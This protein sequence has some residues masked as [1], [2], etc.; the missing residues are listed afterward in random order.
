MF[1]FF[2]FILGTIASYLLIRYRMIVKD[3]FGNIP[4][5]EKY[6]GSGGTYTFILLFAVFVFIISLM[7]LLGTLDSVVESIFGRFLFS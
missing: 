6:L 7:Y 1:R 3:F 2:I 5:A 4:F